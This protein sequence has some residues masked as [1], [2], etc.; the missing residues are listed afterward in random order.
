MREATVDIRYACGCNYECDYASCLDF[1]FG[2]GWDLP[3]GDWFISEDP[4]H[5]GVIRS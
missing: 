2:N 3:L 5:G 4:L 1:V